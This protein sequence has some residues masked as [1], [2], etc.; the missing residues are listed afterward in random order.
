MR[1]RI[2]HRCYAI[3]VIIA[4]LS[5]SAKTVRQYVHAQ[6]LDP[7]PS[8]NVLS[9]AQTRDGYLWIGT[10]A[11]LA[12]FNGNDFVVFDTHNTLLQSD[13]ISALFAASDGTLWI[14]TAGGGLYRMS[15]GGIK[16]IAQPAVSGTIRALA[17]DK[18]HTIWA[19]V[20][21]GIVRLSMDG[22]RTL[23]LRAKAGHGGEY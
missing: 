6:W 21:R 22:A 11:G 8:A 2:L 9:L 10:S 18:E 15:G 23:P 3:V 19:A 4:S 17:E 14:G 12:R 13:T 1:A 5:V 20:D 7:L 16:R